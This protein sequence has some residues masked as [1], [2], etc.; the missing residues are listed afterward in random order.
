M[1]F[2]TNEKK[3]T[4]SGKYTSAW[5]EDYLNINTKGEAGKEKYLGIVIETR[6]IIATLAFVLII[7]FFVMGYIFKLQILQGSY[8]RELA[9]GN[10]IKI[11]PVLSERGV[12]Y[13]SKKIELVRNIPNFSI[14]LIPQDLPD[15][16]TLANKLKRKKIIKRVVEIADVEETKIEELL[17]KYGVYSYASLIIKDNIDYETAIKLYVESPNMPGIEVLKG[18]KREYSNNFPGEESVTLSHIIGYT[19][20]LD[21]QEYEFLRDKGYLLFDNIGKNGIEKTYETELRGIYGQKKVEVD[22]LGRETTVLAEKKP[23][24]G[25]NL[26]LGLDIQ[27]QIKLEQLI[28]DSL[29]NLNKKKAAGIAMNPKTGAIIALVSYPGFNNNDFVGGITVEKYK[30]YVEDDRMPLFNRA[31]SGTYPSGSTVKMLIAAAALEEKIIDYNK[32]IISSGGLQVNRWFFPDWKVGG[33]GLTNV[34][35]AIAWSINTFFYYVGGGYGNFSGL[36]VDKITEYLSDFN[37]SKKTNIDLPAE[38]EGFLPS[39]GWKEDTKNESWYIGDT[40]NL[41]IGQGDLLVTPLQ[42][43]VWTSAIAN[44]G[45]IVKPRVVDAIEDSLSGTVEKNPIESRRVNVSQTNMSIVK[46]G[47]R[48]CVT[49]GSC[50]LLKSLPFMTGGKTGTAQ[51][52]S[53]NKRNH[54]WFTSFAPYED[55]QIVVTIIIEEGESGSTAAQPIARDFLKW[56]AQINL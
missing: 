49:Y 33:H 56:W 29:K 18:S 14:A 6:T 34:T 24:S 54:A 22:A 11:R 2:R 19:G 43:A 52:N 16:K 23:L 51:W 15:S 1:F 28:E 40:Y 13:D 21:E 17:Q 25:K 55:P 7:S 3:K 10:R 4:G 46:Q 31:I 48:E 47:M 38:S 30:K 8:Y 20:K 36:G 41:S 5:I 12:I 44:G 50:G 53:D 26:I 42:V 37:L 39:R 35:K 27:A 9:E 45:I 32:T